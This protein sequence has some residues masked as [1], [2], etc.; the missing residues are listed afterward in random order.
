MSNESNTAIWNDISW[1]EKELII[2][3]YK[4]NQ[5]RIN[6]QIKVLKCAYLQDDEKFVLEHILSVQ[7]I[8]YNKS[9]RK[10]TIGL[11]DLIVSGA[12]N[13]GHN[14][15][16]AQKLLIGLVD[17]FSEY[18]EVIYLKCT[19]HLDEADKTND[20]EVYSR[21]FNLLISI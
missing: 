3:R 6:Q 2:L 10:L 17:H 11:I 15:I 1:C 21:V 8:D 4:F 18:V 12:V 19:L 14:E 9:D 16:L 13:S 20:Y 7:P 5:L